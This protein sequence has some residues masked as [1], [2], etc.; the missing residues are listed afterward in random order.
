[1]ELGIGVLLGLVAV[2]V[3]VTPGISNIWVAAIF[4]LI[5]IL[6]AGFLFWS[7]K[8]EILGFIASHPTVTTVA[9]VGMI[10]IVASGVWI[11][12]VLPA[13]VRQSSA[14]RS[15]TVVSIPDSEL[16]KRRVLYADFMKQMEESWMAGLR[17]Q[18]QLEEK[19]IALQHTMNL[20]DPLIPA[21]RVEWNNTLQDYKV[22]LQSVSGDKP[23]RSDELMSD[24]VRE[25]SMYRVNFQNGLFSAL[26]GG[27]YHAV[28]KEDVSLTVEDVLGAPKEA[29]DP[30]KA[31][32][33]FVVEFAGWAETDRPVERPMHFSPQF[34]FRNEGDTIADRV[35]TRFIV[36][37]QSLGDPP[38]SAEPSEVHDVL[39]K[40][41]NTYSV[42]PIDLSGQPPLYLVFGL[43][44]TGQNQLW[45]LKWDGFTPE[46]SFS[47]RFA[48]A[49]R[50][51]EQQIR[52][53]L[54]SR[55]IALD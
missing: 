49:S 46:G 22:F 5:T 3:T 34:S 28:K 33:Y 18:K 6:Y 47:P 25:F 13:A 50:E 54:A 31:R 19:L 17:R 39:P 14:D 2:A 1:M 26:F 30:R 35:I 38:L 32:P 8:V 20:I 27:D 12:F 24:R 48:S 4:W 51:Q 9:F 11:N 7:Q 15:S 23:N 43:K 42:A 55:S 16:E 52:K 41:L 45:F 44:Y 53:F 36:M 21:V 37:A 40:A 10:T 29:V